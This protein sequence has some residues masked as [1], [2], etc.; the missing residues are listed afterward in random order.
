MK[1]KERDIQQLRAEIITKDD[2]IQQ[3][4]TEVGDRDRKLRLM[5]RETE[6][7]LQQLLRETRAKIKAKDEQLQREKEV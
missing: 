2:L 7:Q 6:Q 4:Q 3:L 1:L 5:Q